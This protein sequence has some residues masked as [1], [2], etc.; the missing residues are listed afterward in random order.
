MPFSIVFLMRRFAWSNHQALLLWG[1]SNEGL[2]VEV[3]L[4]CK[5]VSE[6]LVWAL[7]ISDSGVW[8]LSLCHVNKEQ[9]EFWRIQGKR[10]LLVVYVD[11]IE[12]INIKGIDS[13]NK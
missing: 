13:L 5:I 6:S 12:I 11:D 2:Q 8:P 1:V 10:I 7:Y 9:Y 3:T 4:Q